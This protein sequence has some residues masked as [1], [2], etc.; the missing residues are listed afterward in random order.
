MSLARRFNAGKENLVEAG[1][2]SAKIENVV[3]RRSRD[4]TILS[5]GSSQP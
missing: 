1:V 4:E 2:A 3:I 5:C